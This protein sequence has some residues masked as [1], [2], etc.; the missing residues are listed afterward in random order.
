MNAALQDAAMLGISVCVAAGDGG[1]SDGEEDKGRHVD[2]PAASPWVLACGGTRLIAGEGGM[3]SETVW[4]DT[5]AGG[6]TGGGVS[7][8]FSKPSYQSHVKVPKPKATTNTDGRGLPDIAGVADPQTGYRVLIG[9]EEV[10][11]GGT[12]AVAPL[13]SALLALCNE[14]IGKNVGWINPLLYNSITQNRV[15]YD[16]T[17]GTNGAYRACKG[18]DCCTGLGTPDG[19]AILELLKQS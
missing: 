12:S 14:Q 11:V 16:I 15:T 9:G 8:F 17:K 19:L 13:W 10:V 1:S 4:N 3:K 5:T 7:S 6:S 18:W 2:F